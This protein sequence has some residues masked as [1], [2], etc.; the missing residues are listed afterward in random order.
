MIKGN[1]KV[2]CIATSP[3]YLGQRDYEIPPS[4]WEG[5]PEC[6]HEFEEDFCSKCGAWQGALG[7]EPTI[8]LYI[9]HLCDIYDLAYQVLKKTGTNWVNLGDT[10]STQG[11][12][13]RNTDK[14]YSHYNSIKLKNRMIGVPL[15]KSKELPSK[16]LSLIPFRFAIE[17]INRGWIL[18]NVIIWHKTNPM[19]SS[20]RDRFTVDFEYVF[21]FVKSNKNQYWINEKTTQLVSKQPLGIK[22]IENIDWEWRG[23][24]KC[25]GTGIRHKKCKA[26]KEEGWLYNILLQPEKCPECKGLGRISQNEECVSCKGK[27][28]RK[29]NFWRGRQY[30]FEQQRERISNSKS[31]KERRK[32]KPGKSEAKITNTS[33]SNVKP[34]K[35]FQDYFPQDLPSENDFPI[36]KYTED[37]IKNL[38][39]KKS[40]WEKERERGVNNRE[41]Y[42]QRE[43]NE[44]MAGLPLTPH[45]LG[46][47]KRTVWTIPTKPN[48]EAHFATFPPKLIEPMILSGCPEFIC[49]KCGKPREKIIQKIPINVKKHNLNKGKSRNS[50]DLNDKYYRPAPFA[51]TG[52]EFNWKIKQKGYTDCE[53]SIGYD[54]KFDKKNILAENATKALFQERKKLKKI[55][56]QQFP[57][58]L[59]QQQ[60]FYNQHKDDPY[61]ITKP[62]EFRGFTDYNHGNKWK[63]GIVL[64]PFAG[65]GT[66][67]Y[68]AWKLGRNYIG[69]EISKE[70]CQIAEKYLNQCKNIR[71]DQFI[72]TKAKEVD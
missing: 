58:S 50:V 65:I 13:N 40:G 4:I 22:G 9:K 14:D 69:F 61:K 6:E 18:R 31:N 64:D 56:K 34:N 46:K 32:Y 37:D 24:N 20:A 21:F 5:I 67:L 43:W 42:Q 48:P 62:K 27:G 15:I 33:D 49:K 54:S 1:I 70:Y 2:D 8:G 52:L 72:F 47:N 57:K 23:C 11:G 30:F 28:V 3:P 45:P 16:C 39:K 44:Y 51:R 25:L 71:L 63:L 59:S 35:P 38:N 10:Y 68:Q 53:C 7:L 12:Q 41:K 55:A 26:C 66:T 36:L 60:R 17:M 19:P 29:Y